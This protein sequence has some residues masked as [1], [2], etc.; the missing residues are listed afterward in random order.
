MRSIKNTKIQK[1]FEQARQ[2]FV[3]AHS[4]T[5]PQKKRKLQQIGEELLKEAHVLADKHG[6]PV[7]NLA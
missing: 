2:C 1:L 5:D 6:E 3:Q 4:S 7:S